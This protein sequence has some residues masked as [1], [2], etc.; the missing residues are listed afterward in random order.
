MHSAV[1]LYNGQMLAVVPWV[2]LTLAQL[3][4][5]APRAASAPSS[6]SNATDPELDR[7]V[8]QLGAADPDAR[9]M[10][11]DKLHAAGVAAYPSLRAAFRAE[12]RYEVRR[13]IYEVAEEIFIFRAPPRP[14]G[15]LGIQLLPVRA[16]DEPRCPPD[17]IWIRVR[18][19][20]RGSGAERAGLKEGDLITGLDGAGLEIRNGDFASR[21]NRKAPRTPVRLSVLRGSDE[22]SLDAVLG[23]SPTEQRALRIRFE[24]WWRK[25]FDPGGEFGRMVPADL[26]PR[27][28]LGA[29]AGPTREPA[30]QENGRDR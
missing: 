8:A 30:A 18:L 11:A 1:A 7:L 9:R 6:I 12:P 20:I 23:I 19:V 5:V 15:F 22:L 21:I 14:P 26:D 10:A 27:W 29:T 3:P 24:A 4:P 13:A 16:P 2:V 25:E 28:N 17:A